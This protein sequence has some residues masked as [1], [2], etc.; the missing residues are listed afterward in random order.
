MNGFTEEELQALREAFEYGMRENGFD[1]FSFRMTGKMYTHQIVEER[2]Y[3]FLLYAK[4]LRR[5][6]FAGMISASTHAQNA[7]GNVNEPHNPH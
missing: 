2:F 1:D 7:G 5:A 4:Q 3:G 6:I